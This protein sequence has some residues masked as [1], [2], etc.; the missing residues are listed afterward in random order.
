M[1]DGAG[2]ASDAGPGAGPD[3]RLA[4][5]RAD[6][7]AACLRLEE[8]LE[9]VFPE[10]FLSESVMLEFYGKV[11]GKAAGDGKRRPPQAVCHLP[12]FLEFPDAD[13]IRGILR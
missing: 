11:V 7:C 4:A 5:E 1:K 12:E 6:D 3:A 13:S 9:S 10:E 2:F 8:A